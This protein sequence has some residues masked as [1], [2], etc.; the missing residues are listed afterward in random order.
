[1]LSDEDLGSG[2]SDMLDGGPGVDPLFYIGRTVGVT[3]NARPLPRPRVVRTETN[4]VYV[5][6]GDVLA[7]DCGSTYQHPPLLSQKRLQHQH[8]GTMAVEVGCFNEP[9]A[10]SIELS[11]DC[12][13]TV[14][15]DLRLG[16]KWTELGPRRAI[17]TANA[18]PGSSS[19]RG[20]RTRRALRARYPPAGPD[21]VHAAGRPTYGSSDGAEAPPRAEKA[22]ALRAPHWLRARP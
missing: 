10:W 14:R 19:T 13:G 17:P 5:E 7:A 21:L 2:D 22:P 18:V 16:R 12:S 4:G 8:D 3:V 6:R 9:P 20:R 11:F 15:V 1:M